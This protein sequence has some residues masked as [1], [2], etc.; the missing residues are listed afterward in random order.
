LR[1]LQNV[2]TLRPEPWRFVPLAVLVVVVSCFQVL[3]NRSSVEFPSMKPS[4][5]RT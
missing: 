4:E 1:E 5:V 2:V 3:L